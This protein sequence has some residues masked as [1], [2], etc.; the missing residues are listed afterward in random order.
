MVCKEL[1]VAQRRWRRQHRIAALGTRYALGGAVIGNIPDDGLTRYG[2]ATLNVTSVPQPA[3]PGAVARR[4]RHDRLRHASPQYSR[5]FGLVSSGSSPS[6]PRGKLRGC[7]VA[8]RVNR[9]L[10]PWQLTRGGRTVHLRQCP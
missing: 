2:G 7:F 4:F 10:R 9:H 8:W 6:G 1:L 3:K 5:R